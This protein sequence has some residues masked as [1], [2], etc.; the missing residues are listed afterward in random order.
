QSG[1][2]EGASN[3]MAGH[4]ACC[5]LPRRPNFPGK[6]PTGVGSA[7]PLAERGQAEQLSSWTWRIHGENSGRSRQAVARGGGS[8][9]GARR[10][11]TQRTQGSV[12]RCAGLGSAL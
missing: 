12:F 10:L 3:E 6:Q 9:L 4:R 8:K 5:R 2:T 7:G 11:P 1:K